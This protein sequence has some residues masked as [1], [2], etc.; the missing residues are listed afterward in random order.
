MPDA[1]FDADETA[2]LRRVARAAGAT[3]NDLLIAEVMLAVAR[4]NTTRGGGN[5]I[6]L[7]MPMNVRTAAHSA[8]PAANIVGYEPLD[9]VVVD[10]AG[11]VESVRDQT[12]AIKQERRQ[13]W[14]DELVVV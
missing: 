12:A 9:R 2:A 10:S 11:L 14:L 3:L 8:A 1:G 6:R 4:Q 7:L 5:R 13:T